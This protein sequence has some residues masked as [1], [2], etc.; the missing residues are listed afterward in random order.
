MKVA[1]IGATDKPER[2]AH[3]AQQMLLEHGHEPIPISLAGQDILGRKG[4]PSILDIPEE[5]RPV[6]TATIYVNP[7]RFAAAADEVLE[8]APSRVIF[9]PGTESAAIAGRFREAG[10]EVVEACTLVMLATDQFESA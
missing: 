6:H 2:Y 9:N 3:R 1:I 5:E 10:I 4:Y 8:F 7:E